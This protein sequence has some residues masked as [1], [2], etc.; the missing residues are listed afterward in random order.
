MENT[1]YIKLFRRKTL[2]PRFI[3][4]FSVLVVIFLASFLFFTV[5]SP[6]SKA[7]NFLKKHEN[8]LEHA[9]LLAEQRD[10]QAVQWIDDKSGE[11]FA[12]KLI[13]K[14]AVKNS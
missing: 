14:K 12:H 5:N 9:I 4:L 6:E 7:K 10:L 8:D 1:P 13:R 3:V 11:R 2:I